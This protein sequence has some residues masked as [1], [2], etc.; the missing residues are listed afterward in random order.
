MIRAADFT[1]R[2]VPGL[3]AGVL[4]CL[5]LIATPAPFAALSKADAGQVVARMFVQ[6]AWLSLGLGGLLLLLER[7]VAA[8]R[9]EAAQGSQFSLNLGLALVAIFCTVAGYYALQPMMADAKAGLPTPL[10]FGQ[11]HAV[12]YSLFLVKVAAV[13]TLAVRAVRRPT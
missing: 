12:S 9:A 6:E 3:W 7:R 10:S 8:E 5:V 2:F 1:R 11:M 13:T 4:L